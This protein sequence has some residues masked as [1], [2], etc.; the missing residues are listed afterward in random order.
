MSNTV[1]LA[2]KQSVDL[3]KAN[4]GLTKIAMGLGW[5]PV[6]KKSGLFGLGGGTKDID[7]DASCLLLDAS[8]RVVD[9]VWFRQK[10]SHCGAIIHSGDNRTGEGEGD[11]ETIDID[12]TRLPSNVVTLVFTVN[13]FTGQNFNDVEDASS[14][15]YDTSNGGKKSLG[16]F[17]LAE[18]GAHT[19]IF[20]AS[21]TKKDGSW[22]FT[23]QGRICPGRYLEDMVPTIQRELREVS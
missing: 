5:S 10:K 1:S 4:P 21:V 20:I 14:T 6:K 9:T 11:D 15:V 12:L 8:D 3:S 13:S 17:A 7:L 18:K 16:S 19:G 23:A 2:K 22:V